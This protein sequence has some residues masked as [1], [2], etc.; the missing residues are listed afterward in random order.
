MTRGLRPLKHKIGAS[1]QTPLKGLR[2]LRIPAMP[3]AGFAKLCFEGFALSAAR[4]I[5]APPQTPL[6]RRAYF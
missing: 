3:A 5:G 1:P 2:P 4:L 6:L